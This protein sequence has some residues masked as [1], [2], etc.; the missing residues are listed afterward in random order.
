MSCHLRCP[1]LARH[2]V[3]TPNLWG[4]NQRTYSLFTRCPQNAPDL[5][6]TTS[7][8]LFFLIPHLRYARCLSLASLYCPLLLHHPRLLRHP[9]PSVVSHGGNPFAVVRGVLLSSLQT[10]WIPLLPA[11]TSNMH[12]RQQDHPVCSISGTLKNRQQRAPARPRHQR[13]HRLPGDRSWVVR[14]PRPEGLR[15]YRATCSALF[16]H[17]SRVPLLPRALDQIYK[18]VICSFF[19]LC[20]V[21]PNNK[22]PVP[23]LVRLRNSCPCHSSTSLFMTGYPYAPYSLPYSFNHSIIN[24]WFTSFSTCHTLCKIARY[25]LYIKP[26]VGFTALLFFLLPRHKTWDSL[27]QMLNTIHTV[28]SGNISTI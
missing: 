20:A 5:W 3:L 26:L 1:T 6:S 14:V 25:T 17:L 28:H 10:S 19:A 11:I 21:R 13:R 27:T 8:V 22:V 7:A 16:L 4:L 23:F 18:C 9:H 12:R 2:R 24:H 15:R